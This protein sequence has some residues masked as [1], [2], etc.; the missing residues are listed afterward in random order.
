MRFWRRLHHQ[1]FRA[2]NANNDNI[3]DEE[4]LGMGRGILQFPRRKS[5]LVPRPR[6]A[7]VI[8]LLIDLMVVGLLLQTF[9]PLITLLRRNEELFGS[10]VALHIPY[11]PDGRHQTTLSYQ[12][13]RILHQTTA[14]ETI[15]DKWIEPQQSCKGA[16]SDF[17]YKVFI[18]RKLWNVPYIYEGLAAYRISWL[19]LDLT[20]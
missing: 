10:R 20:D 15:P 9:E 19:L 11:T 16:Y 13:P 14:T 3:Y 6:R 7:T 5:Q 18:I 12:I 17:E 4:N 2:F 8:L 1:T